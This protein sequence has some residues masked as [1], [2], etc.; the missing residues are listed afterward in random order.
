M[1]PER[2]YIGQVNIVGTA[3]VFGLSLHKYQS[4]NHRFYT[5]PVYLDLVGAITSLEAIYAKLIQG[6]EIQI[7]PQARSD[8]HYLIPPD[9]GLFSRL[10]KRNDQL[11]A[12]HMIIMHKQLSAP[13]FDPKNN[14]YI[15]QVAER[16]PTQRTYRKTLDA[17]RQIVPVALADHWAEPLWS[18]CFGKTIKA[19]ENWG[20]IHINVLKNHERS[21]LDIITQEIRAQRLPFEKPDTKE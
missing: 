12:V 9:K 16:P 15:Y 8:P 2:S 7:M 10:I 3:L 18:A 5:I 17:A 19:C 13:Q 11:G 4:D 21:W 6:K 20:G 1:I 14:H